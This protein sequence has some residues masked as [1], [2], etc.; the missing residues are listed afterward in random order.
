MVAALP[1]KRRRYIVRDPQMLG[2][3]V[4]VSPSGPKVFVAVCRDQYGKQ[5][6]IKIGSADVLTVEES[7]EKAREAIKRIKQGLPPVEP[8]PVRPDSFS[9]IAENWLRHHV[10]EKGLRSQGDIERILQRYILPRLG[11]RVFAS[12]KRSDITALLDH[13]VVTHGTR[14]A[15][16]CLATIHNIGNWHASRSDDYVSPIVRGMRRYKYKPR[17]RILSDAELQA[18]WAA[19]ESSGTFGALIRLLLISGQR[20]AKVETMKFADVVDGVWTIATA[21]REKGNAGVLRLPPAALEIIK[22]QPRLRGNPY[23]FAASGDGPLNAV[24]RL[25]RQFDSDCGVTGWTLHDL[26]RTS[27]SLLSRAGVTPDV[28]ERVLG[29]A[30]GG[31]RGIY[32]HH[33]YFD[34]KADAIARLAA[35]IERIVNSPDATSV[36]VPLRQPAVQS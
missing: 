7:R 32:D 3:Y 13:I 6:W 36:V 20:R 33:Q 16:I 11:S 35:L 15:D 4:R 1:R 28:G 24:S 14:Q 2:H 25:K 29:H 17:D 34:E 9:T 31:I 23:V 22:A 30:V 5:K 21:E 26:R 8:P 10:A 12:I 27:R 18:I 19:A